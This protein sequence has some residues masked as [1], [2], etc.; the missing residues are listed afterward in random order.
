METDHQITGLPAENR[1]DPESA[2]SQIVDGIFGT[3]DDLLSRLHLEVAVSADI[4]VDLQAGALPDGCLGRT[5][6]NTILTLRDGQTTHR[7][8]AV[9]IPVQVRNSDEDKV[10]IGLSTSRAYAG[11]LV[12]VHLPNGQTLCSGKPTDMIRISY[13]KLHVSRLHINADGFVG[14]IDSSTLVYEPTQ[15]SLFEFFKSPP[16]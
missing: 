4:E 15:E 10:V 11:L 7:Y 2:P 13:L 8:R 14:E 3:T 5:T 16:E 6:E 9:G 1:Y 12:T